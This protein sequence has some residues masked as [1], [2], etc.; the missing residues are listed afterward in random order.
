[1][2]QF[3]IALARAGKADF[4]RVRAS[5]E[6]QFHLAGRCHIDAVDQTGHHPDK[7][8]HRIGFHRVM[9]LQL[10]RHRLTQMRHA[11]SQQ[12]AVIS[13]K[14]RLPGTYRQ[15]RKLLPPNQQ[16]AVPPFELRHCGMYRLAGNGIDHG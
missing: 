8:W 6:R 15:D 14:R 16:F 3:D 5:I 12:P 1:M 10:R 13:V 7:G 4:L 11:G 2:Q 9:Q